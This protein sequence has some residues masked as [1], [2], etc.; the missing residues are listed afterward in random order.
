MTWQD[1]A[2][3]AAERV[4]GEYNI[5]GSHTIDGPLWVVVHVA[6]RLEGLPDEETITYYTARADAHAF[7]RRQS[8]LA[9]VQVALDAMLREGGEDDYDE[10]ED[11][12]PEALR[13]AAED[14]VR[15]QSI[16]RHMRGAA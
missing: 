14:L 10:A 7:V 8:M 13:A 11:M 4:H 16:A 1:K 6:G 3:D 9:A 15:T 2:L 5:S 12:S